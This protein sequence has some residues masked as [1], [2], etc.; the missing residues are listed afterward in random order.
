M[1]EKYQI[2]IKKKAVTSYPTV[3]HML[4]SLSGTDRAQTLIATCEAFAL[5]E[6]MQDVNPK[7]LYHRA[8]EVLLGYHPKQNS[9]TI[10]PKK[11]LG[12]GE[13]SSSRD[14]IS[15]ALQN[16]DYLKQI[17]MITSTFDD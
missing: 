7:V 12:T 17:E 4:E 2:T 1:V 15:E 6:N 16:G 10:L 5:M 13:K 9:S 8:I 11:E 3:Q 14:S